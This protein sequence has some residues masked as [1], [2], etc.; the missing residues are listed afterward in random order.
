MLTFG[1]QVSGTI[2]LPTTSYITGPILGEA[3]KSAVDFG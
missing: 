1:Q 2:K 3:L